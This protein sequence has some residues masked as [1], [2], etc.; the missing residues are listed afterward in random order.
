[1]ISESVTKQACFCGSSLFRCR[2]SELQL[3]CFQAQIETPV[4]IKAIGHSKW[5]MTLKTFP[6][7]TNSFGVKQISRI[8][9]QISGT[10]PAIPTAHRLHPKIITTI[11]KKKKRHGGKCKRRKTSKHALFKKKKLYIQLILVI[12]NVL[13]HGQSF[14]LIFNATEENIG[15]IDAFSSI[16]K[17]ANWGEE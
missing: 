14:K 11:L 16:I 8:P 12:V 4:K 5:P 13:Y 15:F 2:Y 9:F 17:F 6:R 1:M 3:H 7:A 10:L